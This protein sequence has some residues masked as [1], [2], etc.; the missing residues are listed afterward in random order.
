MQWK[1][2][3]LKATELAGYDRLSIQLIGDFTWLLV[4]AECLILILFVHNLFI[5]WFVQK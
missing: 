3:L 4:S 2:F 1:E 5:G